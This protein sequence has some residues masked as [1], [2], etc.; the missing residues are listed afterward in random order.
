M[1][2]EP[3]FCTET[4]LESCKTRSQQHNRCSVAQQTACEYEQ[5]WFLTWNFKIQRSV[6]STSSYIKLILIFESEILRLSGAT[7]S[8]VKNP[9]PWNPS[10]SNPWVLCCGL[11]GVNLGVSTHSQF[12]TCKLDPVIVAY[13]R[14]AI[15]FHILEQILKPLFSCMSVIKMAPLLI[16]YWF[17]RW[18]MLLYA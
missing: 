4:V 18:P 8:H 5:F 2:H 6:A 14:R 12:L 17:V 1:P 13:F 7:H 15:Y 3:L 16:D 11:F 10:L 9:T